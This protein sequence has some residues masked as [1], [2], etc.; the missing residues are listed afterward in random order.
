MTPSH[1]EK[2][3][4]WA[5]QLP[6]TLW[7]DLK[8]RPPAESAETTGATWDGKVFSISLLGKGYQVHPSEK[9]IFR[10]GEK[11]APVNYQ[12]GVVLLNTLSF[13]KGVPPSGRMTVPQDL[14][15]G[16][17]FFVGA[18]ALETGALAT[19]FSEN[20]DSF[21]KQMVDM[22]GEKIDGADAA[23]RIPGLPFVP[24]YVLLWHKEADAPARA[25]IGIDDRAHFHLDL[26]SVFALTNVLVY[27]LCGLYRV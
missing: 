22:G 8:N 1:E 23:F 15:G 17:M 21:I 16:R 2:L 18:H 9:I 4:R 12:T 24:L 11:D 25:V 10:D 27:R 14:P 19:A 6:D 3:F 26:A 5:T 20:P 13:S 7:N